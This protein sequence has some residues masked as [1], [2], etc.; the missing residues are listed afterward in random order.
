MSPLQVVGS[1]EVVELRQ[2][3]GEDVDSD[4]FNVIP[5]YSERA[6]VSNLGTSG[7]DG[8]A[9]HFSHPP[10]AILLLLLLLSAS[11]NWG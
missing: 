7:A 9:P 5:L 11:V 2:M 1:E 6:T 8:A 10:Q 3:E 4:Q